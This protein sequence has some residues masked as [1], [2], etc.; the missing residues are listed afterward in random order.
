[1]IPAPSVMNNRVKVSRGRELMIE[2]GIPVGNDRLRVTALLPTASDQ[3]ID[4]G[5]IKANQ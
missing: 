4:R 2:S 3:G 5:T 1:M